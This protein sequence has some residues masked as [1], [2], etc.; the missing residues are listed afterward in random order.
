MIARK[1][2]NVT[3]YIQCLSCCCC[4]CCK[5][6]LRSRYMKR[7]CNVQPKNTSS[8]PSKKRKLI[9]PSQCPNRVWVSLSLLHNWYQGFSLG[10]RC[11]GVKLTTQLHVVPIWR[12][13]GAILTL[14]QCRNGVHT[15]FA[16]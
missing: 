7:L 16:F 13:S 10:Y 14:P 4:C 3:L 2:L 8:I 9:S 12:M 15:D 11:Q 5:S 1:H 6:S